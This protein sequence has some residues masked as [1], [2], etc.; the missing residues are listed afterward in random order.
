MAS[1]W[2]AKLGKRGFEVLIDSVVKRSVDEVVRDRVEPRLASIGNRL[3]GVETRLD[4]SDR[5][6]KLEVEVATLKKER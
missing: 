1:D 2:L 4:V 5:L 6:V 3:A